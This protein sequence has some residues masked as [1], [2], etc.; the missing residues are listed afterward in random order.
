M[1]T[2][3][4]AKHNSQSIYKVGPSFTIVK[5]VQIT[6]I[7]L[8]FLML[9]YSYSSYIMLYSRYCRSQKTVVYDTYMVFMIVF[10][11]LFFPRKKDVQVHIRSK[12]PGLG[13][14][15]LRITLLH[16]SLHL[17]GGWNTW[18]GTR[19]EHEKPGG[20]PKKRTKTKKHEI[21]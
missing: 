9:I 21:S 16:P 8:W 13:T 5:L 4:H 17:G 14:A 7:S 1:K 15:S 12:L 10:M 6:P 3:L 2:K 20:I 18:W 19:K 11:C